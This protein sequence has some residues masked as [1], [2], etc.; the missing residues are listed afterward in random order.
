MSHRTLT[1]EGLVAGYERGRRVL[2]DA[3]LTVPAGRRLAVVVKGYPRLSETFVAQEILALQERG[4]DLEIWSL[5]RPTDTV[6]VL[7]SGPICCRS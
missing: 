2:D 5:R 3:S 7:I 4:I 1:A 6:M